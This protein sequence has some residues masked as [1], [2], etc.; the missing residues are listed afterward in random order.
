MFYS[1]WAEIADRAHKLISKVFTEISSEDCLAIE[2]Y[3]TR[4]LSAATGVAP[5]WT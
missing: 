2:L 1:V 5:W 3:G 4:G